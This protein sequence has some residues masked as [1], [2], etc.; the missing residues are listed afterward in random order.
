[1]SIMSH[2]TALQT[3]HDAI[4]K[5][6]EDAYSHHLSDAE[7]LRMKKEKLRLKDEIHRCQL[8]M[9]EVA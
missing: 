7:L 8:E 9:S 4:D 6:I 5:S 1:M 2:L 3:K